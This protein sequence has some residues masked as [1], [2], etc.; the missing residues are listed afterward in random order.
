VFRLRHL[1]L[2]TV[3]EHVVMVHEDAISRDA[4]DEVA[5]T[6]A[7]APIGRGRSSWLC[8]DSKRISAAPFDTLDKPFGSICESRTGLTYSL[9]KTGGETIWRAS[10]MKVTTSEVHLDD[11]C[12]V[13]SVP[14]R[15]ATPRH[16]PCVTEK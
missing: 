14:P 5:L 1:P 9:A 4:A 8:D 16:S 10:P 3:R 2:D 12:F 15:L 7:R 13:A 6:D 11:L